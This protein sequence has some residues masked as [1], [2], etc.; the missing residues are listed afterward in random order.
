MRF[1][2]TVLTTQMISA[3]LAVDAFAAAADSL[4]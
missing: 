2:M 4:P 3:A 1:W